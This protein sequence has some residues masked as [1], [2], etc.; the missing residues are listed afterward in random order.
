MHLVPTYYHYTTT[1]SPLTST[2]YCLAAAAVLAFSGC[3]GSRSLQTTR[4]PLTE[5]ARPLLQCQKID[6][7]SICSDVSWEYAYFPNFRGQSQRYANAELR[8]YYGIIRSCCSN[9]IVHFLCSVYTPFCYRG[10]TLPPCRKFCEYV[11][12]GCQEEYNK[13]RFSWPG[14]LNCDNF[15]TK[16][17]VTPPSLDMLKIPSKFNARCKQPAPLNPTPVLHNPSTPQSSGHQQPAPSPSTRRHNRYHRSAHTVIMSSS[18]AGVLG[19]YSDTPQPSIL[20][21]RPV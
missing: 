11:R 2:V 9:A 16:H 10:M 15:P 1:M 8:D 4:P 3:S 17:C 21:L 13:L 5:P 20:H 7:K 12:D 14:H 18:T 6:A 19:S